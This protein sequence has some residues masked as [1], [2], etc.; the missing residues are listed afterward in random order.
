MANVGSLDRVARIVVGIVL[1]LVPVVPPLTSM[2]AGW[3]AWMWVLPAVGLVLIGTA[4]VR[5]CP[6]YALLGLRTNSA[7]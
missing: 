7:K 3:G 2:V 1:L 4:L 5:F 6:A